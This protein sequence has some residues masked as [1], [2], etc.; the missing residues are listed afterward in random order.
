[1]LPVTCFETMHA[2]ELDAGQFA[3]LEAEGSPA[4]VGVL[5]SGQRLV[6][7]LREWGEE[8]LVY[9]RALNGLAVALTNVTFE[10]E[11]SSAVRCDLNN[12]QVGTLVAKGA[13]LM[14]V[15]AGN[16]GRPTFLNVGNADSD[17]RGPPVAFTSWR[18]V[19]EVNG[20]V[21]TL[22]EKAG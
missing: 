18:I 6:A 10:A 13:S 14:L 16:G 2:E 21:H 3:Y 1:M 19:R 8:N 12:A 5:P 4:Y 15:C 9:P 22:Y 7:L 17:T 11:I 20:E